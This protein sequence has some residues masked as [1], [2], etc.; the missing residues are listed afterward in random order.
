MIAIENIQSI[1]PW[2]YSRDIESLLRKQLFLNDL[3]QLPWQYSCKSLENQI[4]QNTIDGIIE[5]T[6]LKNSLKFWLRTA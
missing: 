3:Q 5:D 6:K 1:G 4:R 2:G